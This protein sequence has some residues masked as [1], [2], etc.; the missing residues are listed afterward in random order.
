MRIES[1]ISYWEEGFL[2]FNPEKI[3][4]ELFEQFPKAVFEKTNFSRVAIEKFL[5]IVEERILE[6]PD[7][8]IDSYWEQSFRNGPVYK[9]EI[10]IENQQKIKITIKRYRVSFESDFEFDDETEFKIISFLRSLKYGRIISDIKTKN[11][12]E[13]VENF[14]D[15]WKL[16]ED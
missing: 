5:K 15:Y 11:F 8:I 7:F 9:F 10:P 16:K 6:P 4:E 3:R 12:S 2:T 13:T 1:Y 14:K